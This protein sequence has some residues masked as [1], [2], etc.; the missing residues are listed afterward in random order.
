MCVMVYLSTLRFKLKFGAFLRKLG[1][2]LPYVCCRLWGIVIPMVVQEAWETWL[3]AIVQYQPRSGD[4]RDLDLIV[5]NRYY[6]F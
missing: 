6:G 5:V 4:V 1:A 3:R 2:F